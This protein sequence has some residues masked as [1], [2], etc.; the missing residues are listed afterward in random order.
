[1]RNCTIALALCGAVLLAFGTPAQAANLYWDTN[2]ATA[3]AG[4]PTPT[5]TW[6]AATT[7]NWNTNSDGIG[8]TQTFSG[9]NR[10]FFAA[11]SDA[12]GSY[13]VTV[14]GTIGI[15]KQ[16]NS[17]NVQ[18]G[19]VT[20]SGGTIGA[21]S[22][23][24]NQHF[25]WVVAPGSTLTVNSALTLA[26]TGGNGSHEKLGDGTMIVNGP[27]E[28][29][30]NLLVGAGTLLYNT[31]SHTNRSMSV[32][33]GGTLGGIGTI[34]KATTVNSGGTLAP[35]ES[36]GTLT[37][38]DSLNISGALGG[39]AGS[40]LFELGPNPSGDKVTL[41]GSY[42]LTIG[43]GLLEWDDFVFT[44][45]GATPGDYTLFDTGRAISGTLGTSLTGPVGSLEGTLAFGDSGQ[46]VVL[47]L[48][49]GVVVPEP[50]TLVI[51][52]LGLLGLIGWRRRRTK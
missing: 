30:C 11:G 42:L 10:A 7:A 25:D 47:T 12:T 4:G 48:A 24:W 33:N 3:G 41:T 17:V 14:S 18:E 34:N 35:G 38:G 15:Q 26:N 22:G 52:S 46:D 44:D 16:P 27:D 49:S 51:W 50:S 13:T 37:F 36:V 20:L 31:T 5:G 1:M 23:D 40:M 45:L 29:Q 19:N 9:K 21:A 8:A 43:S 2:G 28:R 6:D 32:N 39:P